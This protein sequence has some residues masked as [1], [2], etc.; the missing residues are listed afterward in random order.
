[1][2]PALVESYNNTYRE[3]TQ[4]ASNSINS[5]NQK[6]FWLTF[7]A[8]PELLKPKFEVGDQVTLS[9]TQM[10]FR[11]VY[12]PGWTEKL[13]QVAQVFRD[14]PSYYKIKDLQGDWLERNF[15][16]ELL[17]KIYKKNDVL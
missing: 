15:Y 11:K 5:E 13:F 2:T 4:R 6:S 1:M 3:S 12:L 17:R 7:S 8:N 14:N 16:E 9:M 10:R